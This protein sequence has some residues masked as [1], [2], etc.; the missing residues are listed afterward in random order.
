M[1]DEDADLAVKKNHSTT[2]E[3]L[4]VGEKMGAKYV[5]LT[6]FSQ[7]QHSVPAVTDFIDYLNSNDDEIKR[8]AK[9]GIVTFDLMTIRSRDLDLLTHLINPLAELRKLLPK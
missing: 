7:R 6:H 9:R 8:I 3:A 4:T 2:K 5:I 1:L